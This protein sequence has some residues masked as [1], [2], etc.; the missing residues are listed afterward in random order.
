[1]CYYDAHIEQVRESQWIN[2]FKDINILLQR[3]RLKQFFRY[4]SEN[5]Q[6]GDQRYFCNSV[7]IPTSIHAVNVDSTWKVQYNMNCSL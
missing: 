4:Y 6:L 1:M 3:K 7:G 2:E 5:W